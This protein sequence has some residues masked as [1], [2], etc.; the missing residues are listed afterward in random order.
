MFSNLTNRFKQSLRKIINSGRLTEENIKET[1]RE[2]RKA[3]LEADVALSVIK[4]FINNIKTKSIGHKINNSLTPG[5]EF[6]KIVRSELISVMGEESSTLNLSD[7]PPAIVLIVGLQGSGKTTS[8]AK[9]AKWIK[10]KYRKKILITS[11]DVNRAAA[12][13]QLKILSNDIEIDFFSTKENKTSIEISKEAIKHAKLKLYDILLIDTAGRLHINEEMMNEIKE[14]QIFSKPIETLLVVDSMMGQDA[15]NMAQIFNKFLFIS[16]IVLS[17]VDGDSRNGVA[18]SMRYITNKPIKFIGTG[19]KITE[20]KPFCPKKIADKILGMN[21]VLSII[22]D[23]E[24]KVDKSHLK[25]LNN[26]FKKSQNFNLDDF[27]TQI[28]KMKK[29]GGLNHLVNKLL[30]NFQT[31]DHASFNTDSNTLKKIEAI[32]SSMTRKERMMP[33][34]IKGSRK[35]RI[36]LGSGTQVQDVNKL[37]KNFENIKR[38]I[39]KIQ[40]GGIGNIMKNIKNML[41]KKF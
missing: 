19:E 20:L 16:G 24:E 10:N 18:L 35:K 38:T 5:Q 6:I 25:E 4:S 28:K 34:I 32:I 41:P 3:L 29:I 14:I 37:L 33:I 8:L 40:T 13:Q 21:E 12:I 23:I 9:I 27:L 30:K 31:S 39:K 7:S 22:E 17:K 1:I 2:V 11:T 15:I 26:Q 36:A